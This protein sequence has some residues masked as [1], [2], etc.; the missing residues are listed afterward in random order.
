[1]AKIDMTI[2]LYYIHQR[3]IV[4]PTHRVWGYLSDFYNQVSGRETFDIIW[5][6]YDKVKLA[7]FEEATFRTYDH[8]P[9]SKKHL[10]NYYSP[11]PI[12]FFFGEEADFNDWGGV[13]DGGILCKPTGVANQYYL[14][15]DFRDIA[16]LQDFV[17]DPGMTLEASRHKM[18]K[19]YTITTYV[20]DGKQGIIQFESGVDYYNIMWA[21]AYRMKTL[22]ELLDRFGSLVGYVDRR[23]G[24]FENDVFR[25]I[26]LLLFVFQ[27]GP[28]FYNIE[29]GLTVVNA[30]PYSPFACRVESI[31]ATH[32]EMVV[33]NS[34]TGEFYTISNTTGQEFTHRVD[35]T[36]TAIS[37]GD[38]LD[39][40]EII[41]D[42][43]EVKAVT[44]NPTLA[45]VLPY[46]AAEAR[47]IYVIDC[48]CDLS[49]L[50][51]DA[52]TA[53]LDCDNMNVWGAKYEIIQVID[54][55]PTFDLETTESLGPPD[56]FMEASSTFGLG[57]PESIMDILTT[58]SLG[59]PAAEVDCETTVDRVP[60]Q[61]ECSVE[62]TYGMVP[63]QGDL[64]AV[65]TNY[66]TG[67]QESED[68]EL[69]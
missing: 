69:T 56:A 45:D 24:W 27:H 10:Q 41:T 43:I 4:R 34:S 30:F 62:S 48:N 68:S 1:M 66:G 60:L 46:S 26:Y 61:P 63:L 13:P 49:K 23:E 31:S 67:I 38:M 18:T 32:D 53:F 25:D 8:T 65:E 64:S 14:P 2:D 7:L 17:Y 39:A 57:P 21:T 29:L 11:V 36:W 33:S 59:P 5:S 52:T 35:G 37:E 22:T 44:N 9:F 54:I 40:Y 51:M 47:N 6:G 20:E 50:D 19:D 55:I 16:R 15:E 3:E 28:T 42:A 58:E 12:Q